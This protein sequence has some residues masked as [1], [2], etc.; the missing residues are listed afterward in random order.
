MAKSTNW[1]LFLYDNMFL[2]FSI[3]PCMKKKGSC[4][5]S[6]KYVLPFDL[7]GHIQYFC[8]TSILI[9]DFLESSNILAVTKILVWHNVD[10]CWTSFKCCGCLFDDTLLT[11]FSKAS[12]VNE[13]NCPWWWSLNHG[14]ICMNGIFCV[15][16]NL[17][18]KINRY[19]IFIYVCLTEC[20]EWA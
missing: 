11:S 16:T 12:I 7:Q 18:K 4:R 19:T 17:H 6:V 10:I 8:L 13:M 2:C 9:I 20:C 14:N 5:R 1:N 15:S 3:F